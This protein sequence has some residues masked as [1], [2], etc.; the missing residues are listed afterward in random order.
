MLK[1]DELNY[2][3][4]QIKKNI[5][6]IQ[7]SFYNYSMAHEM[8]ME[9]QEEYPGWTESWLKMRLEDLYYLMLAFLE[10]R[11]MISLLQ[12]F[13]SKYE[14]IINSEEK[15]LNSIQIDPEAEWSELTLIVG[16]KQFLEPFKFFDNSQEKKDEYF[17]VTSVLKNT[18]FILKKIKANI[19]TEA[20]IYK[21]VKWVLGLYYPTARL[22]NKASF[23]EEFKTY[24]PDIL[25]PE[26]K[27]A[28]EYKYI[29]SPSDN[30]DEFIDQI[31][32]DATNYVGDPRYDTFFAV[33]YI[34]DI[35]IATPESIEVSW[36]AKQFPKNWHL[37][38]SGHTIKAVS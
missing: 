14:T 10:G 26:L 33:V 2:L 4:K 32:V 31:K 38:L 18:G 15:L 7:R 29:D 20:D 19:S 16:F 6:L 28:I 5:S 21:E 34:E 22:K 25:I 12:T 8:D 11:E 23:I 24:S 9:Y 17:K 27:V 36:Q 30:I 35:S 3:E 13:K 1:T 37:I